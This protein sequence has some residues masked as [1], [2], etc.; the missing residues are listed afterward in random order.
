MKQL[1][2]AFYLM[3]IF[4]IFQGCVTSERSHFK[5]IADHSGNEV[6]LS[7]KL[8]KPEG[9]GPFPA[10][11]LLH[12]CAGI[13]S[14]DHTW[15]SKIQSWGYVA[16]IVDSLGPRGISNACGK[17]GPVGY[18]DRAMD[19]YSAKMYL[20]G[21]PFVNAEKVA[22]VGWS[23]GGSGV[24]QAIDP[25]MAHQLPPEYQDSFQAAISFYPYCFNWLDNLSAPLLILAAGKDDWTPVDY[26]ENR[27]PKNTTYHEVTLQIYPD[28][29]HCFD[30]SGK[31]TVY[32][33]HTLRY[34][35]KAARDSLIQVKQFLS[36]YLEGDS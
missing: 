18:K 35:S 23:M 15:A 28:A 16:F 11:I 24:L 2:G 36:K 1:Q 34:N 3:I 14:D 10:V 8:Y 19:A 31:N 27:M 12:R 33:G 4:M 30:C 29:Y 25:M 7:G 13:Q 22:V 20:A 9:S 17:N 26:C 21:L 5:G 32:M 6:N